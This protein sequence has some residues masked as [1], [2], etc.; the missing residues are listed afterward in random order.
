MF[1][2][3]H[4]FWKV[5]FE[6]LYVFLVGNLDD[7]SMLLLSE[8]FDEELGVRREDEFVVECEIGVELGMLLCHTVDF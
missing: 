8:G 7:C 5:A 1:L 3:E 6:E 4:I 2:F